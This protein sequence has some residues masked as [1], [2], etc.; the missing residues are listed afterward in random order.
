MRWTMALRATILA[1]I[2]ISPLWVAGCFG[3]SATSDKG[4]ATGGPGANVNVTTMRTGIIR[5]TNRHPFPVSVWLDGRPYGQLGAGQSGPISTM[6][7]SHDVTFVD[8]YGNTLESAVLS[9]E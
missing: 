4:D 9:T 3:G 6:A 1:S 7:G 8:G 5:V 2:A